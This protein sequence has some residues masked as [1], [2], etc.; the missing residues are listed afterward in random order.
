MD[1]KQVQTA[2]YS[3]DDCVLYL[4]ECKHAQMSDAMLKASQSE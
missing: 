1:D 2:I 4:T 3:Y